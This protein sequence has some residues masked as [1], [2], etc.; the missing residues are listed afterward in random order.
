[1]KHQTDALH[2]KDELASAFFSASQSQWLV[3][4]VCYLSSWRCAMSVCALQ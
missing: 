4:V 1:M 3:L 2:I